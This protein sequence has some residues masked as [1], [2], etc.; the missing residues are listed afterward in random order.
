MKFIKKNIFYFSF[1]LVI[2]LVDRI[3]KLLI[4]RKSQNLDYL[5]IFLYI[6]SKL[7]CVLLLQREQGGYSGKLIFCLYSFLFL[8]LPNT[9][10]IVII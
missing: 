4:L 2:F 8:F 1:I 3:T 7:K 10:K 5:D 9:L 6:H